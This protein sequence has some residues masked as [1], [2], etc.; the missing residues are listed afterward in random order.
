MMLEQTAGLRQA[1]RKEGSQ[2]GSACLHAARGPARVRR[3]QLGERHVGVFVYRADVLVLGE[4]VGRARVFLAL[5]CHNDDRGDSFLTACRAEA[6]RYIL[7]GREARSGGG[8]RLLC[9]DD[10]ASR[11]VRDVARVLVVQSVY[12]LYILRRAKNEQNTQSDILH[13]LLRRDNR[14][15]HGQPDERRRDK[16]RPPTP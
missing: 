7:A 12:L 15:L 13:I 8:V 11:D 5:S 9:R 6:P 16:A 3:V 1:A 2:T 4:P 14:Q 10:T